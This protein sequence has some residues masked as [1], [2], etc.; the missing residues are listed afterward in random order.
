MSTI[1]ISLTENQFDEHIRPYITVA[2]RGYECKILLYKV[3]NYILYQ[4]HTGCQWYQLPIDPDPEDCRKKEISWHAV[5]YHFRKWSRD[6]SLEQVWKGSILTISEDLNL[7]ELNLDGSHAMAKKG[8]ESVA[9]QG[10]KK[11]KTTNILPITESQGFIIA[12]TGLIA[13]NHNDAY[14]L[15]THL[16]DAFK[17]IKHLGLD[18]RGAFF[19]ADKAFDTKDARKTCFNHAVIPNIDENKRNRKS[20]KRGRKRLFN[21][22][23]YKHRFTSE[24]SFAWIDKFRALLVRFYRKDAYFLGAHFIVFVMINLRHVFNQ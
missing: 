10:R 11:G 20:V 4:L 2:K 18:I 16:Q 6:G 22:D 17:F 12:S 13:G 15:K 3:F 9:Y 8:G 24:R 19:N 5:Y 1:P 7:S 23:V 14:N 21:T